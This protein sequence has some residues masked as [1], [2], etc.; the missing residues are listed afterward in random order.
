MMNGLFVFKQKQMKQ[1]F[2]LSAVVAVAVA[3]IT[4]NAEGD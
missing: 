2:I 4:S 3:A 1:G